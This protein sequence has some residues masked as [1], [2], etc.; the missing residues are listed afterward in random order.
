MK[1]CP[2]NRKLIA[3]L[4]LDS[5]NAQEA[6]GLRAHL[7]H[8]EGCRRYAEEIS[9]VTKGLASAKM[10]SDLEASESFHRQVTAKLQPVESGSVVANLTFWFRETMLQW[11]V[12][13]PAVAVLAIAL[14]VV[15]APKHPTASPS[16][17]STAQVVSPSGS[18]NDLAPTIANYQMIASQS[19]DKLAE[20]LTQQ[21]NKPLPPAPTYTISSFD[22]ANGSY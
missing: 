7:A 1:A 9:N 16:P 3:W 18:A 13:L 12:A 17:E 10:D 6:A 5:L 19:P 2:K 14:V 15:I 4:V 11:R 20:L 22:L 8:C 21:G